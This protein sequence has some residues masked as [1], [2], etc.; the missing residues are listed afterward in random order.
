MRIDRRKED[1]YSNKNHRVVLTA[2]Q[3]VVDEDDT[4][5]DDTTIGIQECFNKCDVSFLHTNRRR[6]KYSIR[7]LFF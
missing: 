3:F 7:I 1:F 2:L 5:D 4:I 6:R